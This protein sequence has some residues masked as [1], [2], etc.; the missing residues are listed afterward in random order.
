MSLRGT[1]DSDRA[2]R[3]GRRARFA[4][5]CAC[6]ATSPSRTARRCSTRSARAAPASRNFSPGADCALDAELPARRWASTSSATAIDVAVRGCRS[7]RLARAGRRARLRQLGHDACACSAACWPGAGVFAV[8][9]GDGSLRRRPM[10]RVV[11][12]LRRAG[13][14]D[15]RPRR[16]PP[17]A[18]GDRTGGHAARRRASAAG[19]QRAGQVGAAAGGPVRRRRRRRSSSRR[20]TRDHT[21]RC[22]GAMGADARAA[23][24]CAITVRPGRRVALRRRRGAGRLLVGGVLAGARRAAPGRRD[25]DPQCRAE[26]DAAPGCSTILQQHGRARRRSNTNA[27]WPASPS[28]TWWRGPVSCAGRRVGGDLVPLAIDEISLVALLGL[29]ADGETVVQRRGRTAGQGV[30]PPGGRRRGPA[31]LGGDVEATDRRLAHAAVATAPR[32]DVDSHGDHRMAM[33]FALAGA[34]GQGAEIA[35]ADSVAIS[36]PSFWADL[37][38]LSGGRELT[39][40]PACSATRWRTR[41]RRRC[42]TPRFAALGIDAHYEARDVRARGAARGGRT[43]CVRRTASAPTSPRRTSRRCWPFMDERLRRGARARRA[44]HDRQSRR[45]TDRRQHRRARSGALDAPGR[46]RPA[47]ADQPWSS[48]PAAPRAPRSGR[49]PTSGPARSG[50]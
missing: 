35:G 23:T 43:R 34:L 9:S 40:G 36:Y 22:C 14:A 2:R 38:R 45:A 4:A 1:L 5:A 17:A 29:F 31:A 41:S 28:P 8:L 26:P 15:R 10:A 37:E 39:A 44:Q 6:R 48:A 27:T 7:A 49:W 16:R 19:R 13:R 30:R 20:A 32:A 3:S 21:E 50:C 24:G 46:H 11:E 18:A 47:R 12:P 33:L 25:P 42:T